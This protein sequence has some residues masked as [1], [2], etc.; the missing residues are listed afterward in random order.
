MNTMSSNIRAELLKALRLKYVH[1]IQQGK[2]TL[3]IYLNNPVGIG[4]HPQH[5]EEMDTLIEKMAA[6]E[7]KLSILQNHFP[8]T[9]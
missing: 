3:M 9:N 1:E 2:A 5:L 8:D 7:D 6:A 4:E